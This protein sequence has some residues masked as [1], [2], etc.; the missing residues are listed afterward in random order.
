MPGT[1]LQTAG[2]KIIDP[3]GDPQRYGPGLLAGQLKDLG[4]SKNQQL[5][6]NKALKD[7]NYVTVG[8][9]LRDLVGRQPAWDVLEEGEDDVNVPFLVLAA[10]DEPDVSLEATLSNTEVSGGGATFK[11]SG[12]GFSADAQVT[13]T[14]KYQ[15]E[16][17]AGEIKVASFIVPV[18]WEKRSTKGNEDRNWIHVEPMKDTTRSVIDVSTEEVRPHTRNAPVVELRLKKAGSGRSSV[19][20]SYTLEGGIGFSVGFKNEAAGIEATM[21]A[22]TENAMNVDLKASLP[23]GYVYRISWLQG[24]PGVDLAVSGSKS[25]R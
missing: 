23:S 14:R 10:P 7:R 12:T 8:E 4:I 22:K 16:A 17:T 1:K 18:H 25:A 3:V 21:T 13:V 11:I 2:V 24:P 20:Q 15:I 19:T 5:R 6:L 9:I